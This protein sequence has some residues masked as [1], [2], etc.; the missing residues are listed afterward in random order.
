MFATIDAAVERL[1]SHFVAQDSGDRESIK[2]TKT[3]QVA[4]ADLT[5]ALLAVSRTARAV[6]SGTPGGAGQFRVPL[7][8]KDQGLL[9]AANAIVAAATPL[10]DRF[11]A[12]NLPA[13]FLDGLKAAIDAFEAAISRRSTAK[14]SRAGARAE[15]QKQL[16][17]ALATVD[18]L[19]AVVINRLQGDAGLLAEWKSA[20]HVSRLTVPYPKKEKPTPPMTPAPSA[21]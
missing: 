10:R 7:R 6:V 12:H 13:T 15:I 3:K 19:D 8:G 20:R 14:E 17:A 1:R 2:G 11:V 18:Q 16:S 4:R 9:S 5:N 21:A